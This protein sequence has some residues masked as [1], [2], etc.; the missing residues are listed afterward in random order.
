MA[1]LR[2]AFFSQFPPFADPRYPLLRHILQ[3]NRSATHRRLI[4]LWWLGVTALLLLALLFGFGI[5]TSFG[6]QPLPGDLNPLDTFYRIAYWPLVMAQLLLRLLALGLTTGL[7]AGERQRRTWESLQ[8]TTDGVALTVRTHA[9]AI[10]YRTWPLLV[11]IMLARLLF[12]GASLWNFV[13]FSGNYLDNMIS[14][15]VPLGAPTLNPTVAITLAIL[16]AAAGMTASILLPLT[17]L[18]FDAALGLVVSTFARVR[19]FGAIA[20]S[21]LLMLRMLATGAALLLGALAI[22]G[23]QATLFNL[24]TGSSTPGGGIVTWIGAMIGMAEG[25]LSLTLLHQPYVQSLWGDILYGALIG[26]GLLG[27][28]LLQFALAQVLIGWASRRAS[29]ASNR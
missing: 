4:W 21:G 17:A 23:G 14:G 11:L 25:D 13:S 18:S 1:V 16:C 26:V 28:A 6:G 9:A 2:R 7:I 10:F 29:H 22:F 24:W 5:A 19:W 12:I 15:T 8:V 27:Y 3:R 20:R